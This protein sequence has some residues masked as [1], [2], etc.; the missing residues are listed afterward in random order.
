MKKGFAPLLIIVIVA[1][2]GLGAFFALPKKA[3]T[4]NKLTKIQGTPTSTS[5][6]NP[7]ASPAPQYSVEVLSST[8]ANQEAPQDVTIN[9]KLSNIGVKPFITNFTFNECK[10]I[11]GDGKEYQAGFTGDK[12]F[13]KAIATGTSQTFLFVSQ[14]GVNGYDHHISGLRKCDYQ[15]NG[16]K[17]CTVL[18]NVR[19][20]SCV[21]YITSDGSQASNGWGKSSLT[22]DFP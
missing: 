10:V 14:I 12:S 1:L 18:K 2:I 15:E 22:V 7:T 9:V 8:P 20:K 17:V 19:V 11:D 6:P 13:E 16:E 5:T 3:P 21:A 4:I